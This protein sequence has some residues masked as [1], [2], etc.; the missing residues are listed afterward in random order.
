MEEYRPRWIVPELQPV[1]HRPDAGGAEMPEEGDGAEVPI[2]AGPLRLIRAHSGRVA[3]GGG[4][5]HRG[6]P[7][8]LDEANQVGWN[9]HAHFVPSAQ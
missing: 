7:G 2:E 5:G 6:K 8:R 4:R 1:D 9:R 3:E